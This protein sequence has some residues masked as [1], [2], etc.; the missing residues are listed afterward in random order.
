MIQQ[1]Y[2]TLREDRFINTNWKYRWSQHSHQYLA[3]QCMDYHPVLFGIYRA[4]R[5]GNF[6]LYFFPSVQL[7]FYN[8]ND[9]LY[10]GTFSKPTWVLSYL[11]NIVST[12]IGLFTT[13]KI[14]HSV[15]CIRVEYTYTTHSCDQ[16]CV[17][18]DHY[19]T[20]T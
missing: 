12:C 11:I 2:I 4:R 19:N 9:C 1:T 5:V 18:C 3:G 17:Q 20:S 14:V 15:T 7:C 8:L 16:R 6:H 13:R 10:I